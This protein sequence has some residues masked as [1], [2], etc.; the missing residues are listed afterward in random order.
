MLASLGHD[1]VL[2]VSAL[3]IFNTLATVFGAVGTP[4]W[5]GFAGLGLSDADLL[6]VSHP[7]DY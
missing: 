7:G 6:L 1:K 2:T 4:V 5:F 3:L